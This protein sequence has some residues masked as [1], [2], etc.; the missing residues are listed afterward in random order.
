M[1]AFA[2][3]FP[4]LAAWVYFDVFSGKSWMLPAYTISKCVQFAL[5]LVW[6]LAVVRVRIRW[7][8]APRRGFGIGL[9][10][11]AAILALHLAIY[12]G[13]FRASPVLAEA[14]A[15]LEE[16]LVGLGATTLPRFVLLAVFIALIHSLLEEYY[17]RWF[18]YGRLRHRQGPLGA[19]AIASLGFMAHHV[20]IIDAYIPREHFFTATLFF[21][22]CVAIGGAIWAWIYE[23]T[24][25]LW[26]GWVSHMIV[27]I[28]IMITGYDMVFA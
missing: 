23:K 3:G 27:D 5:P 19:N 8:D 22:F 7:R 24:G 16:K 1:L 9:V 25:A 28:A 14:P 6:V 2:L 4:T 13:Y 12:Y 11:G 17:W 10:S 15:Q 18:V 21:S 26:G 20:V